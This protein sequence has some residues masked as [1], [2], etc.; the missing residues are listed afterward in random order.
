M[1]LVSLET[2]WL[3]FII[4]SNNI[5]RGMVAV[6]STLSIHL[7]YAFLSSSKLKLRTDSA[8]PL[9][10]LVAISPGLICI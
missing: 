10:V 6:T 8:D 2:I 3:I 4:S 1:I 9:Y 5:A 7:K